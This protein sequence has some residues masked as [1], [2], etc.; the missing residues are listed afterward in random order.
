MTI[1]DATL[2]RLELLREL[3]DRPGTPAEGLAAEAAITRI[4]RRH[5]HTGGRTFGDFWRRYRADCEAHMSKLS[6]TCTDFKRIDRNTLVGFAVIRISEMRL[7]IRDV[8]IHRK[9]AERWAQLPSKPQVDTRTATAIQKDGKIQYST[10]LEFDDRPTRDAFSS[11][12]VAALLEREPG[13]FS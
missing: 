5:G 7:T 9:G 10:I 8:A 12:V 13:A 3:A 6:V 1:D 2:R 11:A 4:M